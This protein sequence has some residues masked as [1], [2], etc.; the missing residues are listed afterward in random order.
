METPWSGNV[1]AASGISKGTP[2]VRPGRHQEPSGAKEQRQ[3]NKTMNPN[4]PSDPNQSQSQS[5]AESQRK[6]PLNYS[7][8]ARPSVTRNVALKLAGH[9]MADR[10]CWADDIDLSFVGSTQRAAIGA[11]WRMLAKEG[12]ISRTGLVRNSKAPGAKGRLV[13][14]WRLESEE[15]CAAFLARHKW[16]GTVAPNGESL[17][18]PIEQ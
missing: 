10:I 11:A 17:L 13:F 14:K 1:F 2:E 15:K 4:Q 9:F 6:I 16:T 12:I 8:N 7:D 5:E 18:F 3:Q